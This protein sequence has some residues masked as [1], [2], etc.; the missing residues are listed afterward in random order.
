MVKPMSS[1]LRDVGMF[2]GN[3]I[4]GDGSVIM[5]I[6][7]NALG[8]RGRLGRGSSRVGERHTGAG[9]GGRGQDGAAAVSRAAPSAMKA[10]PLSLITRLEE[11]E[12]DASS[13]AMARTSVQYR[14]ALMPLVYMHEETAARATPACNPCWCSPRAAS[15]SVSPSIEIVDIVEERLDD[16]A[17]DRHPGSDRRGHR[18]GQGGRDRRCLALSRRG[19]WPPTRS[20]AEHGQPRDQAAARR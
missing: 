10:V 16:R 7:P 20:Q 6:D 11:I 3:T 14:G 13:T 9:G 17:E 5:I 18:Q 2:S 8:D 15:P 19:P 12:R 4:L 1:L